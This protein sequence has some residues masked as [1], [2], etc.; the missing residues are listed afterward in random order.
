MKGPA[1]RDREGG[2]GGCVYVCVH[3]GGGAEIGFETDR[4]IGRGTSRQGKQSY[5]ENRREKK[6]EEAGEQLG[7]VYAP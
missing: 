1:P 2:V 5:E 7:P 6:T 4:Q 3:V